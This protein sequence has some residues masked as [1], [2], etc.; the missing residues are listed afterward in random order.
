MRPPGKKVH[1]RKGTSQE[2]KEEGGKRGE[3]AGS[4]AERPFLSE[5]GE[6][7]ATAWKGGL[8]PTN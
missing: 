2:L 6:E 7:E 1:K 3:P 8:T 5:E 4:N